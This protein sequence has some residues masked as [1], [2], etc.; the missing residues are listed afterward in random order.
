MSKRSGTLA[1]RSPD[2]VTF[3]EWGLIQRIP[4]LS[5]ATSMQGQYHDNV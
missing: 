5:W 2:G 1:L 3:A 4:A